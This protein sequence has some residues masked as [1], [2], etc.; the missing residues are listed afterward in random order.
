MKP[1]GVI[2]TPFQHASGSPIQPAGARE[3][4][5]RVELLDAYTDG[6]KDLEGFSHIILLYQFHKSSRYELQV[7][8]FLDTRRRGLFA[9]RA[10]NRPNPLG[11]SI[12]KLIG[13]EGNVL[14]I[15]GADMLD[16]SPLLDIKPYVPAFDH[17]SEVRSGWFDETEREV[18]SQTADDRFA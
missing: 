16:G 14:Y 11:M 4:E 9:T 13:I 2:L 7:V 1:I 12:V 3:V 10:P 5:G 18:A 8:P 15:K 6:L 17:Q